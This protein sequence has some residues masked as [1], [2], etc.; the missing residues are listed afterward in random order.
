M[1]CLFNLF[2]QRSIYSVIWSNSG[3][4]Q[5]PTDNFHGYYTTRR[6]K[7]ASSASR[8]VELLHCSQHQLLSLE[9]KSGRHPDCPHPS[10]PRQ[11]HCSVDTC[12]DLAGADDQPKGGTVSVLRIQNSYHKRQQWFVC[13]FPCNLEIQE[14]NHHCLLQPVRFVTANCSDIHNF[15][16]RKHHFSPTG[17]SQ[18]HEKR[19]FQHHRRPGISHFMN[20]IRCLLL[21]L[22]DHLW[23]F[24]TQVPSGA[25]SGS[26]KRFETNSLDPF[27]AAQADDISA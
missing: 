4:E 19:F 9:A 7:L 23:I 3:A 27:P 14:R 11:Y 22:Y 16:K 15:W 25:G 26:W 20:H 8:C 5:I 17:I 12:A 10:P 21:I 2:P 1:W 6:S 13:G 24:P 18:L